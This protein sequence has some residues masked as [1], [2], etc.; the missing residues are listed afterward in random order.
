MER[1]GADAEYAAHSTGGLMIRVRAETRGYLLVPLARGL[2][3]TA[4]AYGA[5]VVEPAVVDPDE[6]AF[7]RE[8]V[9]VLSDWTN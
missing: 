4:R 1:T 3:G 7:D 5:I 2:A 6:P 8:H 9:V